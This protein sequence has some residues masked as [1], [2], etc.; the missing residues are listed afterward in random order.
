[1]KILGH[2]MAQTDS[3]QMPKFDLRP[4]HMGCEVDEVAM[5]LAFLRVL[6]YSLQYHSTN[7][8]YLHSFVY[9]LSHNNLANEGSAI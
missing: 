5:G 2:A 1:M 9:R 7:A 4:I 8:P 3:H 6:W